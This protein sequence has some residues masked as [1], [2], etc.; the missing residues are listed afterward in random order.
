MG[1][2]LKFKNKTDKFSDKG[3][4]VAVSENNLKSL[5]AKI[6]LKPLTQAE[7]DESR[8]KAYQPVY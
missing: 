7:I 3:I 5:I 6:E 4:D 8:I 2:S 1:M